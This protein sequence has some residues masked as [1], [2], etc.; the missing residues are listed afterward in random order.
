M[1]NPAVAD[2]NWGVLGYGIVIILSIIYYLAWGN[3]KYVGP[4]EY[5]RKS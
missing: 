1:P 3:K 4:V 5:T 2:M